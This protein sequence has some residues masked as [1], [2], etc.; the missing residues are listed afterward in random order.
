MFSVLL[1]TCSN[2]DNLD[3]AI[4]TL[5]SVL[6]QYGKNLWQNTAFMASKPLPY[7]R[8]RQLLYYKEMLNHLRWN[9]DFYCPYKFP[10]IISRIRALVG[11]E[12][13][14]AKK[15]RISAFTT[16]TTSTTTTST[17]ST[18]TSTS[19]TSTTSSTT[20]TTTTI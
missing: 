5:D 14:I 15:V 18:S 1:K 8:I 16:T 6:A 19:T 10:Q 17:T 13:K 4:C 3:D 20:T 11:G 12:F 9:Q 7:V 2:C